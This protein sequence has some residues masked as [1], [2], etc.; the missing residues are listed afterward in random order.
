MMWKN[1]ELFSHVPMPQAEGRPLIVAH[2]AA[3][4][5]YLNSWSIMVENEHPFVLFCD[6]YCPRYPDNLPFYRDDIDN[7][8]FARLANP[9]TGGRAYRNPGIGFQNML[10]HRQKEAV[11]GMQDLPLLDILYIDWLSPFSE[12]G[13][14]ETFSDIMP[15]LATNVRDGGIIILDRKHDQNISKW[16]DFPELLAST[17]HGV[18][19]EHI[20][21]GEWLILTLPDNREVTA[22][23]FKVSHSKPQ[24]GVTEFLASLMMERRLTAEQLKKIKYKLPARW[25]GHEDKD[26]WME[27]YLEYLD[28]PEIGKPYHPCPLDNS[29]TLDEYSTWV[30]SLIDNPEQLRPIPRTARTL[31]LGIDVTLIHGDITEHLDWLMWKDASLILRNRLMDKC[32]SRCCWLQFKAVNLQPKW[33]SPLISK[34]RWSGQESNLHLTTSLLKLAKGPVV[35]TIVYG[36]ASV[37][38]LKKDLLDYKGDVEELII[39][40]I[41]EKDFIIGNE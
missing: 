15:K 18:T 1:D 37:S 21:R 22:E 4:L 41:D 5:N 11:E 2:P 10:I 23:I 17:T 14:D 29:W 34:L 7:E 3:D 28:F 40:H 30:Q 27:R 36:D 26:T 35:A 39:F 8:Y 6:E 12:Q 24:T 13:S 20:G 31:K 16:F 19:L 25:P 33:E 32:L 38:Q 9:L